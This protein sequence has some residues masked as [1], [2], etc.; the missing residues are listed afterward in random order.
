MLN[1][2]LTY[3]TFVLQ[4]EFL[5]PEVNP[6]ALFK[7]CVCLKKVFSGIKKRPTNFYRRIWMSEVY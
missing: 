7:D 1:G 4:N 5:L 6:N 3:K 2:V